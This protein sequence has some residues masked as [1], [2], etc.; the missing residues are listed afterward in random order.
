MP[1]GTEKRTENE[2]EIDSGTMTE[3]GIAG[4]EVEAE[5]LVVVVCAAIG[6][7]LAVVAEMT[8]VDLHSFGIG[9]HLH[10]DE[11]S[12]H[13]GAVGDHST[14]TGA[15]ALLTGQTTVIH[16]HSV[17]LYA[18]STYGRE[19]IWILK[20]RSPADLAHHRG[21]S[22]TDHLD[23]DEHHHRTGRVPVRATGGAH[24][25]G[26]LQGALPVQERGRCLTV[27]VPGLLQ[28]EGHL[29]QQ[30]EV[31]HEAAAVALGVPLAHPKSYLACHPSVHPLA[32]G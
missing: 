23:H 25:H 11:T 2:K 19:L 8:T 21:G 24:L 15:V 5:G 6:L 14:T 3:T 17:S 22:E 13:L 26:A 20:P 29:Y 32:Q 4:V 28:E 7:L 27:H 9:L 31:V 16:D 1:T 30:D 18:Y 12:R 10:G